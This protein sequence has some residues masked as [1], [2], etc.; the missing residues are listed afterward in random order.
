[1]LLSMRELEDYLDQPGFTLALCEDTVKQLQ[2]ENGELRDINVRMGREM[3][4]FAWE[5]KA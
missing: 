4:E 2:K 5:N 1:M 3:S